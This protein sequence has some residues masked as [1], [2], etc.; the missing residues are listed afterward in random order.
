MNPIIRRITCILLVFILYFP[1][2]AYSNEKELLLNSQAAILID[3][4][5]GDVLYEK[6]AHQQMYPASITKIVTGIMAVESGRLE[7]SAITSKRARW[8]EGTRIYLAQDESKPLKELAFGLLMN[9]GNDAAIVIAEHLGGSVEQFG[10]MM[11]DFV[12][13]KLGLRNT[14]FVNPHGLFHQDHYTT[15]YDMAMIAQYAMKNSTFREIVGTKKRPWHGKEW[16]SSLV[17]HNKLLW[18]YEGTTGIKNGYVAKAGN[19]LVTSARRG[20][21]ELIA[22]CL[23]APGS[24]RVY[25]DTMA[26]LDYGFARYETKRLFSKGKIVSDSTGREYETIQ[27]LFVTVQKGQAAGF[28]VSQ[29]GEVMIQTDNR[30]RTHQGLLK[31]YMRK[32]SN[33]VDTTEVL[34]A[35]QPI[36]A[37]E[38]LAI[39][40]GLILLAIGWIWFK[41]YRAQQIQEENTN[42]NSGTA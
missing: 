15:A 39:I 13:A 4:K 29:L 10:H 9:S 12:T 27:D 6:K 37:K 35:A 38:Q 14:H 40:I 41:N 28:Q 31:P 30:G 7:E 34:D 32:V 17:N 1:P 26:L 22:V 19:T 18:R 24:E 5:T 25:K 2:L 16:E 11:N 42:K 8:A 23:K 3:A 36:K 20:G 21:T 33:Q